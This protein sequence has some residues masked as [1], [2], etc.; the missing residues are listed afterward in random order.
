M[1]NVRWA[2]FARAHT[3]ALRPE[4]EPMYAS[5]RTKL[6]RCTRYWL[7]GETAMFRERGL[8]RCSVAAFGKIRD[9]HWKPRAVR[10]L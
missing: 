10:D 6:L 9:S 5:L 4:P 7:A 2:G 3:L 1:A 8:G